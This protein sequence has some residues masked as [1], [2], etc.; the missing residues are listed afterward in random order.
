M[1][2]CPK[3]RNKYPEGI[4]V[5]P[6]CEVE[7]IALL[8]EADAPAE[9]EQAAKK[10]RHIFGSAKAAETA[11]EEPAHAEMREVVIDEDDEFSPVVYKTAGGDYA[12]SKSASGGIGV[13]FL[14]ISLLFMAA[15][16]VMFW[17]GRNADTAASQSEAAQIVSAALAGIFAI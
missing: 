16:A 5:C 2:I 7:L 9:E 8:G 1:M 17:L 3:C 6:D 13:L 10:P 15:S 12:A 4:T 11:Y 14:V